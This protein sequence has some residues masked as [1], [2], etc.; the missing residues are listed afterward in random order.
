SLRV[1]VSID[2]VSAAQWPPSLV[3]VELAPLDGDALG[4]IATQLA[5]SGQLGTP[6][7]ARLAELTGGG[8]AHAEHPVRYLVA[9][10]NLDAGPQAL[11]DLV[12]AGLSMLPH[13]SVVLLQAAAV[14]GTEVDR[15]ILRHAA[16]NATTE[17]FQSALAGLCLRALVR[18]H[19]D[20][21]AYAN[22]LIR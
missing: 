5:K 4:F 14:F 16:G 7:A 11:P 1:V 15:D 3:R 19:G 13:P 17:A 6:S 21:V 9:G 22:G 20:I 12:G 18:D 10:G 2:P 8:P